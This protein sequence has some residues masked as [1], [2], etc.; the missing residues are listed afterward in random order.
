MRIRRLPAS[1]IAAALP[2]SRHD[3]SS[4]EPIDASATTSAKTWM[5]TSFALS[6]CGRD[7]HFLAQW[8]PEHRRAPPGAP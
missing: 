8:S 3:T 2:S 4:V 6:R 1:L 7:M 5:P